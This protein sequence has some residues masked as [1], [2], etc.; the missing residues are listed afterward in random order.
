VR[1]VLN[2]FSYWQRFRYSA[3]RLDSVFFS[4]SQDVNHLTSRAYRYNSSTGALDSIRL[5]TQAT[6][7]LYDGNLHPITDDLPGS[8]V[9]NQSMG[10]LATLTTTTEALNNGT[11]ERWLGF[12]NLGQIDRH[13][14]YTGKT[15]R[16]FAYDSL[17][18]LRTARTRHQTPEGS[19]PPGCPNFDYGM[20]GS[21]TPNVDYVTFDSIGYTYDAA[22]N[23]T[24]QG[25]AYATGN[26]ITSFGSCTYKTDASGN[27]VSRKGSSPCLQVDTLFWAR[28]GWLDSVQVGTTGI[29]FLYDADGRLTTKRVNGNTVSRFLW[30]GSVLLAELNAAADS[31]SVEYSYYGIDSPHAVIKQP[32]GT[33][34]YA[35]T[36]GLLSVQAL[37]DTSGSIR[38]SYG[39]DDWG[40]LT[41][42]SDA[43][44]FGGRDR[45][46]WKGALWLGPELD[47][48]YMRSRW[49]EPSSGRFLS[50]DPVGLSSG[51]NPVVFAGNDPISGA[52]PDGMQV[53]LP[54]VIVVGEAWW[55]AMQTA[56]ELWA[57]RFAYANV[58]Y[59][60]YFSR[61]NGAPRGSAGLVSGPN[62]QTPG[63]EP[64]PTVGQP[65]VVDKCPNVSFL[66]WNL[67]QKSIDLSMQSGVEEGFAI[68][69][70]AFV[71]FSPL[72]IHMPTRLFLAWVPRHARVIVHSHLYGG[73][74]S[75]EDVAT[76]NRSGKRV[77]SA[78]AGGLFGA[79]SPGEYPTECH[80]P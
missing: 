7:M 10:S 18:Q 44:G 1:T 73:G 40:R 2:G 4:G 34:L 28:E 67:G 72:T 58:G 53:V 33:R 50:E 3:G 77:V 30:S 64:V 46:R 62:Q 5:A 74:L 20:S 31:V 59:W 35:R 60:D 47:L 41:S 17:G 26:R 32:A 21:C 9:T 76:A 55:W 48:Y 69:G 29:R 70:N 79:V 13:L 42:S 36:D 8:I 19:L 27:V 51:I 43:E 39:Y 61:S 37:T 54:P 22:G 16:W 66:E 63:Q 52:D 56:D 15:G 38:T 65:V 11:L 57:R 25:G 75:G 68:T 23:R 24:D 14:L 12:N 80:V 49:Y 45:V 71:P 78:A 6:K